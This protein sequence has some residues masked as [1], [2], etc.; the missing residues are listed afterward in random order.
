M[1]WA[2]V[3]NMGWGEAYATPIALFVLGVLC[4]II[5]SLY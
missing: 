3:K 5:S 1:S 2:F 4:I